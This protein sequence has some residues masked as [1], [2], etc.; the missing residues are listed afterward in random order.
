MIFIS[1]MIRSLFL[2]VALN[3]SFGI[4]AATHNEALSDDEWH[5][6]GDDQHVTTLPASTSTSLSSSPHHH[7]VRGLSSSSSCPPLQYT[8]WW[9]NNVSSRNCQTSFAYHE[10]ER[11]QQ[12]GI[13][14]RANEIRGLVALVTIAL[15]ESKSTP[16]QFQHEL[17]IAYG[18]IGEIDK[19]LCDLSCV[20]SVSMEYY[21]K[22]RAGSFLDLFNVLSSTKSIIGYSQL[23][24]A[25]LTAL[26]VSTPIN[27]VAFTTAM[28]KFLAGMIAKELGLTISPERVYSA[29]HAL[30]IA[31]NA[32]ALYVNA[33]SSCCRRL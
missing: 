19:S 20:H 12:M 8:T 9:C 32:P 3:S 17:D 27:V 31:R 14:P 7:N 5:T 33:A 4:A 30:T 11:I 13:N 18:I 25:F 16:S 1:R 22:Y 21:C 26:A 29:L 2:V 28:T 6:N 24:A 10:Y 23:G 15:T